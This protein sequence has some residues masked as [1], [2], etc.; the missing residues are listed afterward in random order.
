MMKEPSLKRER[1]SAMRGKGVMIWEESTDVTPRHATNAEDHLE[2]RFA[3]DVLS[4]FSQ[5]FH[6]DYAG[7]DLN[8]LSYL[9]RPSTI[10]VPAQIHLLSGPAP[11]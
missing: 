8:S 9:T 11:L 7:L 10:S 1:M 6:R 3:L 5:P 4:A 2:V